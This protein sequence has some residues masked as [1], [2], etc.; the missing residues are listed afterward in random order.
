M[1]STKTVI[2]TFSK[3]KYF[4]KGKE[5]QVTNDKIT[6]DDGEWFYFPMLVFAKFKD[7][8]FFTKEFRI[9]G[10]KN[11]D[12]VFEP[13][14]V[15]YVGSKYTILK[16]SRGREHSRRNVK[17]EIRDIETDTDKCAKEL[18]FAYNK[19][20]NMKD[21]VSEIKKGYIKHLEFT[22]EE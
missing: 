2:C 15:S 4:T 1:T 20:N 18:E 6:D 19:G 10:G 5:Y 16:D 14:V 13:C 17:L 3:R 7:K 21:V 9:R 22:G 8:P 11:I 12:K